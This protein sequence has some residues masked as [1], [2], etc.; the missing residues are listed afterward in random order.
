M[1]DYPVERKQIVDIEHITHH[2]KNGALQVQKQVY[3]TTPDGKNVTLGTVSYPA[4]DG[5]PGAMQ[6]FAEIDVNGDRFPDQIIDITTNGRGSLNGKSLTLAK[7]A[8]STLVGYLD[9]M[10]DGATVSDRQLGDA[11][12]KLQQ[13]TGNKPGWQR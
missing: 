13:A 11:L 6:A 8:A 10:T 5:K 2:D 12:K 9:A 1:T 3:G 4:R 7:E